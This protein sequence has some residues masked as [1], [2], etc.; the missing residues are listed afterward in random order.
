MI[1][2][3]RHSQAATRLYK[4]RK[5]YECYYNNINILKSEIEEIKSDPGQRYR[6]RDYYGRLS[7]CRYMVTLL[8]KE[9]RFCKKEIYKA[10][11]SYSE[12]DRKET[13]KTNK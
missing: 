3:K 1:K 7:D 12:Y 10:Q 4:A 11:K 9:I 6:L 13:T 8:E 5:D 2:N